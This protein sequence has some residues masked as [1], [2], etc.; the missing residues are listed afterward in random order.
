ML[1]EII[2]SSRPSA[3]IMLIIIQHWG[4]PGGS[5]VKNL[6]A[7]RGDTVVPW[8]GKIPWRRKWQPI[9]AF[10]PGKSHGQRS[11]EGYSPQGCKD[12]HD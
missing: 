6:F 11:M 5:V 7:N 3:L 2:F 4:F 1:L 9:L 8:V 12:G 10:L